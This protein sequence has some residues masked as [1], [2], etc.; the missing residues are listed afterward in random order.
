M[1]YPLKGW[2]VFNLVV[3]YHNDVKE[4][5]VSKPVPVE[6][7]MQG[8]EH[9][10]PRARRVIEHGSNWKLWV[11][12]DRTPVERWIDWRV[13]L[14]GDA[15]HPMLQYLAQGACMA[16]EDAV[17]LAELVAAYPGDIDK[18]FRTYQALR[19]PHTARVQLGSREIG[20]FIYHPGGAAA[21]VRNSVLKSWTP[22]EYYDRLSWLY[23]GSILPPAAAA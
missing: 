17:T 1:H 19:I 18:A 4:A 14:L 6:E 7:V 10:H 21:L 16:M 5:V 11:L 20:K 9:I 15:A 2:K 3:T 13:A 23:G 22:N 8:F 12:C